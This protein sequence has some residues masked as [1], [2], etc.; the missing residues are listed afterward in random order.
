MVDENG[1]PVESPDFEKGYAT[2]EFRLLEGA[3][4]PYTDDDFELV[5][6]YRLFTEEQLAR[7]AELR[8]RQSAETA[9]GQVLA[10]ARSVAASSTTLTD[11]Q[12]ASMPDLIEPWRAGEAV[13]VG[14]MRSHG[15]QLYRCVQAHT[16]QAGWEPPSV[17]A[18]WSPVSFDFEGV[19][20]WRGPLGGHDCPNFGDLRSHGGH[21]WHSLRDGNTSEPGVGEDC[22]RWWELVR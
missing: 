22:L 12:A 17:P 2:F 8:A 9:A 16:T 10:M 1:S 6:V 21:V 7:N 4:E 11:S 18:L 13:E 5:E 15:D 3:E 19:E 20:E 14:M